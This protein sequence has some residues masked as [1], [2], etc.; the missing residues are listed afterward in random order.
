MYPHPLTLERLPPRNSVTD[1]STKDAISISVVAGLMVG[2]MA[3]FISIFA[4]GLED[5]DILFSLRIGLITGSTASILILTFAIYRINEISSK[6]DLREEKRRE[7]T[8]FLRAVL[9]P[10][11]E[12]ASSDGNSWNVRQRI[13]RERGVLVVDLLGLDP[14]SAAAIGER[15]I[16]SRG[17]LRRVKIRTGIIGKEYDS[18]YQPGVRNAIMQRLK[19]DAERVNWQVIQKSSSITL[20]PMGESPSLRLWVTRFGIFSIPVTLVMALAFRDLAGEGLEYQ[21]L[22]FGASSGLVIA[23]LAATYRD[24]S[25]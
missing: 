9:S 22:L 5:P 25:S 21:G 8:D 18:N 10:I 20:R 16:D 17:G 11:E 12:R 1:I 6:G 4:T 13:R 23:A 24:R 19:I 3:V 2:T 15:L 7:E 14:P